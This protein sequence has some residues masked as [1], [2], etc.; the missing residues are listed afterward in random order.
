ME[1]PF[2][3]CFIAA[4]DDLAAYVNTLFLFETD[5]AQFDDIL[6]A[7]SA[8]LICFGRGRARMQLAPDRVA[9]SSEAFFL[10]PM[11]QA[12]PFS[13]EGP[14]RACGI[15]L[16]TLGWA[17]LSRLPV[18]RYG[19]LKMDA[20]EILDA[21]TVSR[22][23][24]IGGS[25][26]DGNLSA[27]GVCDLLVSVMR[28]HIAPPIAQHVQFILAMTEWLNSSLNP[29]IE[30]LTVSTGLSPRQIQRLARRYFGKPPTGLVR[31][32]RAIRA[33]TILSQDGVPAE[34]VDEATN[35]FFDQAHMI[36]DIRHFTGRTPTALSSEQENVTRN[37]LGPEG[38]GVIDLFG[39]TK[40]TLVA[41]ES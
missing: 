3:F 37:T 18:D 30:Q 10:T 21:Q 31:R 5:Q 24:A 15:S 38:Y 6:P 8:Q 22:L 11:Q 40:R 35:A 2:R 9:E 4:P 16:T 27:E 12:A 39:G 29:D 14:V 32:Y 17:A 25:F 41:G 33:A 28:A 13:M 23:S 7:Y 19:H 26:A 36:R 1:Q 20:A 34:I